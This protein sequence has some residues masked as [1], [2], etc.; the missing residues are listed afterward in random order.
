[1]CMDSPPLGRLGRKVDL[2]LPGDNPAYWTNTNDRQ[3]AMSQ[4][5]DMAAF[6]RIVDLGGH[7]GGLAHCFLAVIGVG[8]ICRIIARQDQIHFPAQTTQRR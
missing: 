5:S 2:I 8:P 1:M 3:E 4:P 7:V 6:V